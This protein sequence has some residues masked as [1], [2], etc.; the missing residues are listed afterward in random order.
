MPNPATPVFREIATLRRSIKAMDSSLRRLGPKLQ[1]VTSRTNG[2]TSVRAR[3]K[4]TLSPERRAQLKLQGQYIGYLR[5]LKPGQ[6]AEVRKVRERK[7]I[8]AAI[9]K[10]RSLV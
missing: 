4:P 10:G 1:K 9:R 7:G 6:K 2:S 8:Q 5:N 3:K